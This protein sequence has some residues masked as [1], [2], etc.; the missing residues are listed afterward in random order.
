MVKTGPPPSRTRVCHYIQMENRAHFSKPLPNCEIPDPL[1][2]VPSSCSPLRQSCWF[3]LIWTLMVPGFIHP[4]VPFSRL[5]ADLRIQ[6]SSRHS[7]LSGGGESGKAVLTGLR[8]FSQ[9]LPPPR[10]AHPRRSSILLLSTHFTSNGLLS[11][12]DS[13]FKQH[14]K[15]DRCSPSTPLPSVRLLVSHTVLLR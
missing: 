9:D 1:E 8:I 7:R 15:S 13:T 6:P 14:L 5:T 12:A 11:P 3:E 4:A 2:S 10:A